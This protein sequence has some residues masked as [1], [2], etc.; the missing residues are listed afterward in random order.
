MNILVH[1]A[2]SIEQNPRSWIAGL[3]VRMSHFLLYV[4][5]MLSRRVVFTSPFFP[6]LLF[7]ANSKD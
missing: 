1:M 3:G 2:V 7:Q 4:A 6:F 5:R